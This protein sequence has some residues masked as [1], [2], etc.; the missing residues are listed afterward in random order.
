MVET[1]NGATGTV[2]ATIALAPVAPAPVSAP[3]KQQH[4]VVPTVGMV[5]LLELSQTNIRDF[6]P[7]QQS[8]VDV[9]FVNPP[10]PDGEVFIRDIHRVG[11]RSREKMIWPQTEL[12]GCA[13][14]IEDAGYTTEIIDCIAEYMDWPTFQDKLER[15]RPR[16]LVTNVTAPTLKNDLMTTFLARSLGTT[17][18]AIGSHVTPM[19]LETLQDY[20]TL[21]VVVRH[22]PEYTLREIVAKAVGERDVAW[23]AR[24]RLPASRRDRGQSRPALHRIISMTCRCRCTTSCHWKSIAFRC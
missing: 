22:E 21:D 5:N 3:L 19:A 2:K 10:S 13:A 9:L 18:I 7:E 16:F 11:R 24:L 17:T 20:P 14:V 23:R 12:A 6:A 15:L 1:Q 8:L 4:K